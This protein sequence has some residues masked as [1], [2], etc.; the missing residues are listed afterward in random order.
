V[1]SSLFPNLHLVIIFFGL[2][3]IGDDANKRL[4]WLHATEM[5]KV[6]GYGNSENCLKI[7]LLKCEEIDW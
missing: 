2:L 5:V 6:M 3:P 4:A 1:Y 7:S